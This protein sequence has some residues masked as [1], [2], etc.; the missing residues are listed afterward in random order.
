MKKAQFDIP[1]FTKNQNK[2]QTTLLIEQ[3]KKN[4]HVLEF[5]KKNNCSI[6]LVE[7]YPIKF[8]KWLE[9]I[10]KCEN[11]KGLSTC[12]QP[13]RGQFTDLEWNGLLTPILRT[14]KYKLDSDKETNHIKNYIVNDLPRSFYPIKIEA[15]QITEDNKTYY[16]ALLNVAAWIRNPKEKGY[17][18]YG[19]VGIGK[20]YLAACVSNYFARRNMKVAFI[21]VP[22][23]ISRMKN[24]FDDPAAMSN[25]LSKI[26]RADF[27]VFDDIGA[28]SVTPWVRDELLF[29][30]LN[31]RMEDKKMTWFTS[32]EDFASLENHFKNTKQN[33]QEEMKAVR[34]ME[35]IRTLSQEFKLPGKNRRNTV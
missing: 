19:G 2:P 33:D 34:I 15:I 14:C 35:R 29:P 12:G 5:L 17:Y 25:E 27:V 9:V 23:W 1:A 4:E 6:E 24:S 13:V 32:N 28:E 16:N 22:D 21:N 18:I 10:M 31:K 8:N 20:S 3:L 7:K 30:I 11:C 26:K